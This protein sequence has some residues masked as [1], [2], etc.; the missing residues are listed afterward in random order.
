MRGSF[1]FHFVLL[2]SCQVS[3]NTIVL[4]YLTWVS[5]IF[6]K[7]F[8]IILLGSRRLSSNYLKLSYLGLNEAPPQPSDLLEV[9]KDVKDAVLFTKLD[10]R[11][12]D[13]V[14]PW[15]SSPVTERMTRVITLSMRWKNISQLSQI[16]ESHLQW[17]MTGPSWVSGCIFI[18]CLTLLRNSSRALLNGLLWQGHSV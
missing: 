5:T 10:I 15:P 12:N 18:T 8:E 1:C 2:K 9:A 14:N 13:N 4:S 17:T 3:L 6:I 7:L 16:Y 11:I